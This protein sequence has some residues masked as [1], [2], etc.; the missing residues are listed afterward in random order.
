MGVKFFCS[1]TFE[2]SI[3]RVEDR[4]AEGNSTALPS[5]LTVF[6]EV[7]SEIKSFRET[8]FPGKF[9][10]IINLFILLIK[11]FQ[12]IRISFYNDDFFFE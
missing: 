6:T 9:Q 5:T 10:F 7:D 11:N 2:T 3:S 8:F 4:G 12:K 1:K